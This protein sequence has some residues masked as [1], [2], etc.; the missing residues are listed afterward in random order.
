MSKDLER[1]TPEL[2]GRIAYEHRHRYALC[3]S[4]IDGKDVLDVACGEGYGA[5]MLAQRARRVVGVDVD[6]ATIREAAK[7]YGRN[8]R[9]QFK[10]ADCVSLPFETDS[11][12]VVVSFETIEHI[13]EQEAFVKEASRVLRKGGVFIVSTPNRPIYSEESGLKNPFHVKEL[14][15]PEFMSL[16]GSVFKHVHLHGQRFAIP[17]VIFDVVPQPDRPIQSLVVRKGAAGNVTVGSADLGYAQYFIAI[18]SNRALQRRLDTPSL[19]L[20]ENEDLWREHER[21]FRWASTLN[22]EYERLRAQ[23]MESE[24]RNEQLKQSRGDRGEEQ[25]ALEEIKLLASATQAL[26]QQD[27]ITGISKIAEDNAKRLTEFELA[28]QHS[29]E[30]QL[31]SERRARELED[32]AT[33]LETARSELATTTAKLEDAEATLKTLLG[34]LAKARGDTDEVK[35]EKE[36]LERDLVAAREEIDQ[37]EQIALELTLVVKSNESEIAQKSEV[38]AQYAAAAATQASEVQHFE[39]Q[40]RVIGIKR[41][42]EQQLMLASNSTRLRLAASPIGLVAHQRRLQSVIAPAL[43]APPL[44][45]AERRDIEKSGLFDAAWYLETNPDVAQS[46]VDPLTHYLRNGFKED[47]DP[48]PYFCAAWYRALYVAEIGATAPLIHY[49][50]KGRYRQLSPHPLFD[51]SFYSQVNK[52]VA[53]HNLDPFEHYI[54]FGEKEMRDPHPLIWV[55]RLKRQPGFADRDRPVLAYITQPELFLSS[56]HPLFDSDYY[57]HENSDVRRQHVCPLLHY[58]AIGWREGRQPH[59]AFAGDWYLANNPDVVAAKFNPLEHFVRFGAYE[60]RSPHPLFDIE[61]YLRLNRDARTTTYDALSHYVLI[62]ARDQRETS[63]KISLADMHSIVADA[64]WRRFDPI[65]AFMYFGDTRISLPSQFRVGKPPTSTA[66]SSKVTWPPRPE[67]AYWLPQQMRDYLIDNYGEEKIGLYVYLMSVVDR[68]GDRPNDFEQSAEFVHLKARLGKHRASRRGQRQKV[69]VSIIIPV[70]NNL[71][72]TL[73]S[74]VSIL[75]NSSRYSYEIII[76]D[77]RSSDATAEVFSKVGGSI[78]HVRHEKNLGFLE[79]CNAAARVAKGEYVVFLNND[80]LTLPK[81]L[82]ELIDVFKRDVHV[83]L[84]GSKLLNADGT[85]QEAGGIFWDDGSAWNFGRNSDPRLPEY[86]YLKEADYISGASIALPA[87]TWNDLGGFDTMYKPAYCEDSDLAF[88]VRAAGLKAVYVPHS[89]VVHHEGK[90]HGNDTTS[91]I[92]AYQIA[93]QEKLLKRWRKTLASDHFPNAQSVFL[94]RDRSR[95]RPHILFVDHYVPQWDRDAGSRT[96]YHF[97]RMFLHAGFHVTFW[98]DNLNRDREY[99]DVLQNMGV[100][101]IYSAAYLDRFDEF[102]AANGKYFEYALLSRPHIAIKYYQDIRANSSCRILYYGHDIHYKRMELE[103]K[104]NQNSDLLAAISN[105]R[106]QE[107]DN[108]RK[109]DVVLYPSA[110]EREEVKQTLRGCVAGD[111]PMLGYLHEEL[112]IARSNLARFEERNFDELLFVGGSHPPNVDALVWFATEVLPLV[113][114]A[115]PQARLNVVGSTSSPE[116]A[117][118]GSESIILK[119]R[120]SDEDLA[121]LYAT[122]GV[123]VIPLRFGGGVKGK[124]I[125]A[126]FHATPFVATGVGMQGLFPKEPIGYVADEPKAFAEA[127]VQAQTDRERT[128]SNVAR[129]VGFIEQHY[130][131]DAL[132]RAFMPFIAELETPNDGARNES[133]A[134]LAEAGVGADVSARLPTVSA[135]DGAR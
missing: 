117:R 89:E 6:E 118:L 102:M 134:L 22:E 101:V 88:R 44:G 33:A 56:P 63:E 15:E 24:A 55:D 46:R 78:V 52:D 70:Y 14:D 75:D 1:F 104:T 114:A 87:K 9:L 27:I 84:A 109:S 7:K 95:G 39:Q 41:T 72:F 85:L 108:W 11:F 51:P 23:L 16:L 36:K 122:V 93:N 69:D 124:T 119:G 2:S 50:R 37:Q 99:C 18:C 97:V 13:A 61:H 106:L 20:D 127:V 125:E 80:T 3:A 120:L 10:V 116:I 21:I 126:L 77:D 130:S 79:N 29:E 132:K 92:K 103:L 111:V 82:D 58:C 28:R 47:R 66:S 45:R 53:A 4:F 31:Q 32:A 131:I 112:S 115:R 76:G 64:Y 60:K 68:Y 135:R 43:D 105:V 40:L 128:K 98:P 35:A 71:V 129:G 107:I 110:D 74:V 123:A 81:W 12:D 17:S 19:F 59:R 83:G 121:R 30:L 91:G 42:I 86:N 94:A 49:L 8:E 90:S 65:S 38:I 62:G 67:I 57:L 73:T 96:M 5:D 133:D 113:R 54:M 26:L 48:H 100:E 34:D 25:R